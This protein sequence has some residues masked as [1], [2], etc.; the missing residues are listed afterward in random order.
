MPLTLL[1]AVQSGGTI[2][3]SA[4]VAFLVSRSQKKLEF[5]YSYR[6]YILEKRKVTYDNIE[7]IM[8]GL[9]SS[10]I[11]SDGSGYHSFFRGQEEF[12]A[13]NAAV[14][15]TLKH[16]IWMSDDMFIKMGQLNQQLIRISKEIPPDGFHAKNGALHFHELNVIAL[17]IKQLYFKDIKTLDDIV[18][19]KKKKLL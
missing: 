19:Y 15:D 18:A 2:L 14:V 12:V 9:L 5:E 8:H 11:H 1:D 7:Q 6:E 10:Y 4:G 13:F 16:S 3:L 17:D